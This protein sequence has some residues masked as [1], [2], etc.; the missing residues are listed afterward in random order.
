MS[1]HSCMPQEEETKDPSGVKHLV[2]E[3]LSVS[4]FDITEL[5]T[6]SP[7]CGKLRKQQ[8]EKLQEIFL[9][10]PDLALFDISVP[11]LSLQK[12][13]CNNEYFVNTTDLTA[14]HEDIQANDDLF[15]DEI[16]DRYNTNNINL[17]Q[18][19]TDSQSNDDDM[20]RI[21]KTQFGQLDR[22]YFKNELLQNTD[23]DDLNLSEAPYLS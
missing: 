2:L 5:R 9:Q 21:I 1:Q 17:T 19:I 12:K 13:M 15:T 20:Y 7:E 4:G 16:E 18:S 8:I 14:N 22:Y 11:R 6:S 10:Y 3:R 23:T